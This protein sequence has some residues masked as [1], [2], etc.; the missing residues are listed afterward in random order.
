MKEKL[1]GIGAMF[2]AVLASICCVGPALFIGLG[3][4]ALMAAWLERY[5]LFFLILTI[6]L[7]AVAFYL[8]YG[9]R[10]IRCEDG[11]CKTVTTSRATKG[12]LW[13]V[14]IVALGIL[15]KPYWAPLYGP[16]VCCDPTGTNITRINKKQ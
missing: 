15:T 3:A 8:A 9:K 10:E 16:T 11:S 5:R 1:A 2:S 6:A 13:V 14:L 4:S 12:F 7:L